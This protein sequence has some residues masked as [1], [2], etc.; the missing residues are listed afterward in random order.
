MLFVL[1]NFI[2]ACGVNDPILYLYLRLFCMQLESQFGEHADTEMLGN[3]LID[4]NG[5]M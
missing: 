4:L 1:N 5:V 3:L 2:A